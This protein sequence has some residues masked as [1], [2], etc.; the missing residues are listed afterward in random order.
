MRRF[1]CEDACA[2]KA[3][4]T[5]RPDGYLNFCDWAEAMAKTHRQTKCPG[6]GLFIV[7]V[8]RRGRKQRRGASSQARPPS[9]HLTGSGDE[10]GPTATPY[11]VDLQCKSTG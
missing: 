1:T 4:H 6:C 10:P 7:W 5:P 9:E 2:L 3:Q 8:P 11:F